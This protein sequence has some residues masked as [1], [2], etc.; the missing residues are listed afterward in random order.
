V[1]LLDLATLVYRKI[2]IINIRKINKK[3]L[4]KIQEKIEKNKL[5]IKKMSYKIKK[6]SK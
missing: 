5:K 2:L 1:L 3:K 4:G 6:K